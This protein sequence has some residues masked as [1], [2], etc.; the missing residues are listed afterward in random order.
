LS[1]N[2]K[3]RLPRSK[4][5]SWHS[6]G[7][8]WS[9][10]SCLMPEVSSVFMIAP[11]LVVGTRTLKSPGRERRRCWRREPTAGAL[12]PLGG[13]AY[14]APA[15]PAASTT[16]RRCRVEPKLNSRC[17]VTA[18]LGLMRAQQV[19]ASCLRFEISRRFLWARTAGAQVSSRDTRGAS[20]SPPTAAH[21]VSGWPCPKRGKNESA[22]RHLLNGCPRKLSS[23]WK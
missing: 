3:V 11:S 18:Q 6:F 23:F 4:G 14:W 2:H 13:R 21:N 10:S 20:G 7:S 12:I 5:V 15:G 9:M 1:S 8:G 17:R 19:A 22:A 16:D